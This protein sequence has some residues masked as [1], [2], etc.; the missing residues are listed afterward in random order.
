[1]LKIIK[2][3]TSGEAGV[4]LALGAGRGRVGGVVS[5]TAL[6]GVTGGF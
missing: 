3:D 4:L 5:K 6:Q 1:M 2:I